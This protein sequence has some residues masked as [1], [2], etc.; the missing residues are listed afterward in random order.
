LTLLHEFASDLTEHWS[1]FM[2]IFVI[3]IVLL[4]PNGVAGLLLKL[5]VRRK[6]AG[7]E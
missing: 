6:E 4:M 3:S 7:N 5:G 1:I 2:G